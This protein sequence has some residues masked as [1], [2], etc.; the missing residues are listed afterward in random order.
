MDSS[1]NRSHRSSALFAA[2]RF[3]AAGIFIAHDCAADPQPF[4][5]DSE[6]DRIRPAGGA[7]PS[8]MASSG[9]SAAGQRYGGHSEN[10]AGTVH[11][12]LHSGM[13]GPAFDSC[14]PFD[15]AVPEKA[16]KYCRF[17]PASGSL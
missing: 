2:G 14:Q 3:S 13:P 17:H 9:S 10:P 11:D 16:Y 1:G 6:M 15:A 5:D 8:V 12:P 4:A 7:V